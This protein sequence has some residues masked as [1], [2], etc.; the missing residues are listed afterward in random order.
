MYSHPPCVAH[1]AVGLSA[2]QLSQTTHRVIHV[3]PSTL[4][5]TFS[6][7]SLCTSTVTNNTQ[8]YTCTPIHQVLHIQL[9]VSL[10][11]DCHKQH[12][13]VYMYSHPP[14]VAHSAVGL[15]A[16]RL[17]QTTHRVIHV[18]PST[19]CCTF[20]SRSLCTSTVTNNTQSD[21]CTP[22]HHVLHI[23]Q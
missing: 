8:R 13:E 7:R 14:C 6:S 22:I 15:S 21:T 23:Q 5:C 2:P 4:C 16:P 12:T 11:L 20:S 9:Q 10:H 3:L 18:L 1:P 19:I 17:S